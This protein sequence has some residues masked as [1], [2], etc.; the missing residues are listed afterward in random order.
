MR[1]YMHA[2]CAVATHRGGAAALGA[3]HP[4]A[5]TDVEELRRMFPG[6]QRSAV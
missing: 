3:R 2:R 4:G 5:L 1:R 6:K